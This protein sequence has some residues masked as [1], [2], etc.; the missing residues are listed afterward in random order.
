MI[1][2]NTSSTTAVKVKA[3]LGERRI[4]LCKGEGMEISGLGA[5]GYISLSL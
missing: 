5:S 2:A 4:V 1:G 3:T